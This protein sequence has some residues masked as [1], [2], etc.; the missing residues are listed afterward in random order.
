M[1]FVLV[2]LL[3]FASQSTALPPGSDGE[4]PN[5]PEVVYPVIDIPLKDPTLSDHRELDDGSPNS[6]RGHF[7]CYEAYLYENLQCIL[8]NALETPEEQLSIEE[9]E[10]ECFLTALMVYLECKT[11]FAKDPNVD[12][13]TLQKLPVEA[14]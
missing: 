2:F 8:N 14:R 5:G 11:E 6:W 7:S 4:D 9:L 12:K 10:E 13:H 1:Q 3:V